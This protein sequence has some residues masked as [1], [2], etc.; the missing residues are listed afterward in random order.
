MK[1]L[2][3][4]LTLIGANA[5]ATEY[6]VTGKGVNFRKCPPPKFSG[7]D[8]IIKEVEEGQ[9]MTLVNKG[10]NHIE[11]ILIPTGEKG[12]IWSDYVEDSLT[13][14]K[15]PGDR[16]VDRSDDPGNAVRSVQPPLCDCS[17]CRRSSP[18]NPRRRHPV[19]GTIRPHTGCDLAAATG[20]N[21]RAA[22][23]GTVKF[24]GGNPRSGYGRYI[25]ITHQGQLKDKGGKV[26]TANGFSTRYGHLKVVLVKQG[27]RV[28]K[29]QIIGKVNTS[30][31]ATGP[32]VHFEIATGSGKID[33]ELVI[34]TSDMKKSCSSLAG[35]SAATTQE[36]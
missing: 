2:F 10:D 31:L 23:D 27:D 16:L 13:H 20:T 36:Q 30:G 26:I 15:I 18:F 35:D 29:G 7:D 34:N 1:Y 25:D 8:N 14:E 24:A 9:K 4:L 32:H 5:F 21:V 17:S 19:L 28:K 22:A 6:T 12:C 11:A 3:L 33:P